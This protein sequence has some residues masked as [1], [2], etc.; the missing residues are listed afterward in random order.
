MIFRLLFS[1][2]LI[3]CLYLFACFIDCVDNAVTLLSSCVLKCMHTISISFNSLD[4]HYIL[5]SH[6]I[7]FIQLLFQV[8]CY[9]EIIIISVL[10]LSFTRLEIFAIRSVPFLTVNKALLFVFFVIIRDFIGTSFIRQFTLVRSL[11]S[12]ID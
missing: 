8:I 9:I 2:S 5:V 12:L 11:T 7:M 4:T 1:T 10:H 3:F 6:L